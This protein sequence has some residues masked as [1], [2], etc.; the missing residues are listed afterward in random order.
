M[1]IFWERKL[2][3]LRVRERKKERKKERERE[4]GREREREREKERERENDKEGEYK[5]RGEIAQKRERG[6]EKNGGIEAFPKRLTSLTKST[7]KFVFE[8][9]FQRSF[10]GFKSENRLGFLLRKKHQHR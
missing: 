9:I 2:S 1:T 5:G 6:I 3:I 8:R 10:L 4:R 7:P